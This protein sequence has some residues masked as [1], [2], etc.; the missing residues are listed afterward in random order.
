MFKFKITTLVH[1]LKLGV[2]AMI[3]RRPPTPESV[4][5]QLRQE[6]GFGCCFC[7][8]PFIDYHHIIPWAEDNHF[9]PEDMMV[10]CSNCHGNCRNNNAIPEAQQRRAKHTPKNIVDNEMRGK[11]FVNTERLEVHLG[12][13]VAIDT[14]ILLA[15]AGKICLQARLEAETGRVLLS[16]KFQNSSGV[17]VGELNANE[18]SIRP[19]ALWDFECRQQFAK[20]RS[21]LGNILFE[22]DTRNDVVNIRGKWAIEN[23]RVE[24]SNQ[25]VLIGN[26]RIGQMKSVSCGNLIVVS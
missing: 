19:N 22:V 18:W 25:G 8:H 2:K 12:N 4:K 3:E 9:R 1:F 6:A 16:A 11:L 24:F 20:A 23:K 17:S 5:L 10:V 13:S 14:P 26:T 21:E 7:G 15:I